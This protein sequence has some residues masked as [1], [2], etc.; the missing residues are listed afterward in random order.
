MACVYVIVAVGSGVTVGGRVGRGVTVADGATGNGVPVTVAGAHAVTNN[1]SRIRILLDAIPTIIPIRQASFRAQ[2]FSPRREFLR[3]HK[4]SSRSS[5]LRGLTFLRPS[6]PALL[7]RPSPIPKLGIA[8]KNPFCYNKNNVSV[9][10][11]SQRRN[12]CRPLD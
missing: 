1:T 10:G 8:F 4:V 3:V 7:G 11:I 6:K 12:P 9:A 5:I 2:F